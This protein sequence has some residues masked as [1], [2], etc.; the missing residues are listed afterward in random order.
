MKYLIPTP[1]NIN[2]SGAVLKYWNGGR[3]VNI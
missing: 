3:E 2:S 1:D